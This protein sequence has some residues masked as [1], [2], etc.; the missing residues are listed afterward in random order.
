MK[1]TLL[2]PSDNKKKKLGSNRVEWMFTYLPQGCRSGNIVFNFKAIVSCEILPE[3]DDKKGDRLH[4]EV[5]DYWE[6]IYCI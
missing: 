2:C 6:F 4:V 3:E 1:I 5:D